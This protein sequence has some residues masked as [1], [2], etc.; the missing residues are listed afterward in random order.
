MT[1]D[2]ELFLRQ[3]ERFAA[4]LAPEDVA[5]LELY[6]EHHAGG[7]FV[8]G[9][10]LDDGRYVKAHDSWGDDESIVVHAYDPDDSDA[11]DVEEYFTSGR[12]ALAAFL[13]YDDTEEREYEVSWRINV[14]GTSPRD[15]AERALDLIL[16][17]SLSRVFE[18]DL[19]RAD[20]EWEQVVIDLSPGA[21]I[22]DLDL[23]TDNEVR[24]E[25][26]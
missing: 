15:A 19:K 18:V 13:A 21:G 1:T 6:A 23:S 9:R 4:D 26:D 8:L 10:P 7:L 3:N 2:A 17:G 25:G 12:K 11:D 5:T 24:R 20:G 14:S 22:E 16:T